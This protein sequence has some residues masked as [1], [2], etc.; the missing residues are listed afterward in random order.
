MGWVRVDDSFYDN[1]KFTDITALSIALWIAGLAYCNRNLT[2]GRIPESVAGRLVDFDGLAYTVATVG[3]LGGVMEDD[4]A[5]LAIDDLIRVGLWHR[6]GHDCP[7]CPQPGRRRIYVHDYTRYQ[8]TADE[9]RDRAS[10]RSD[11]GRRGAQ[12]RWAQTGEAT[13]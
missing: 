10:K 13:A 12:A 2:D 7:D 4:C 11:A 3:D 1:P 6:N 9:I 8:F 5:P